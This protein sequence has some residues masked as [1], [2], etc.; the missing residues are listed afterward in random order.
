MIVRSNCLIQR[1]MHVAELCK[2]THE[3]WMSTPRVFFSC[4]ICQ[5]I[6]CLNLVAQSL[7]YHNRR[8]FRGVGTLHRRFQRCTIES[9]K[10]CSYMEKCWVYLCRMDQVCVE[11]GMIALRNE[12]TEIKVIGGLPSQNTLVCW[13]FFVVHSMKISWKE[14]HK[15]KQ[16]KKQAWSI[17]HKV[18]KGSFTFRTETQCT[19]PFV[20]RYSFSGA[21]EQGI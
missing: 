12:Q 9:G 3:R 5:A 18:W 6:M 19:T 15:S 10:L 8:K 21:P 14:L 2:F 7:V 16:R 11:A 20:C 1:R 17:T 13:F 4:S